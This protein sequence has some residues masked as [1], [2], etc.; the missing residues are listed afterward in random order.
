MKKTYLNPAL[1]VVSLSKQ[2][3]VTASTY[4]YDNSG[5]LK[6]GDEINSGTE[7]GL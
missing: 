5:N 3:I 7:Y 1:V 4:Q 6:F 2:D